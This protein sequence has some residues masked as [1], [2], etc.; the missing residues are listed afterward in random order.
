MAMV[1]VQHPRVPARSRKTAPII[2]IRTAA[3]AAA[4]LLAPA[5]AELP[6]IPALWRIAAH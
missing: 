1:R 6:R 2:R 5:A 3:L 4:L